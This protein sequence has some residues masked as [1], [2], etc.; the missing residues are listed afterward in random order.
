[1]DLCVKLP[2]ASS[3]GL[4]HQEWLSSSR[5]GALPNPF[6]SGVLVQAVAFHVSLDLP[7]AEWPQCDKVG[8]WRSQVLLIPFSWGRGGK[9]GVDQ[10]LWSCLRPGGG[11]MQ[12]VRAAWEIEAP[13][14]SK[15]PVVVLSA[16]GL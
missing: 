2:A 14:L 11:W 3:R 8:F 7:E 5:V 16:P 13:C 6:L 15:A 12:R 9:G 4:L 10:V 1:M